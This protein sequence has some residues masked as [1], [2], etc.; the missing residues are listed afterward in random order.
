MKEVDRRLS[1]NTAN[2][3]S[4][5]LKP[6]RITTAGDSTNTVAILLTGVPEGGA[7]S[8]ALFNLY[9]DTLPVRIIEVGD[10]N[11]I[12]IYA[13]DI[14]LLA[15][16]LDE[17]Q[18]LLDVCSKWASEKKIVFGTDKCFAQFKGKTKRRLKL[19][20]AKLKRKKF[21]EYLGTQVTCFGIH[22]N[23]IWNRLKLMEIRSKE[24][25]SL[26]YHYDI[27]P[28]LARKIFKILLVPVMD[29]A[30]H[31]TPIEGDEAENAIKIAC[32]K[33][34]KALRTPLIVNSERSK[35]RAYN[36][37]NLWDISTRRYQAASKLY[38]RLRESR[39]LARE[40][41]KV[42]EEEM[43]DK[44]IVALRTIYSEY[45]LLQ[46]TGREVRKRK[47]YERTL[48]RKVAIGRDVDHPSMLLRPRALARFALRYHF[49]GEMDPSKRKKLIQLH[50]RKQVSIW[51]IKLRH[52]LSRKRALNEEERKDLVETIYC[53][54]DHLEGSL[55]S[56]NFKHTW[57]DSHRIEH[58][59]ELRR[60][61]AST[62]MAA[63][64]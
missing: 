11:C 40:D 52:Y 10:G 55:R 18:R 1:K 9:I 6:T 31:L 51:R 50:G 49:S 2:M 46:P 4:H 61:E 26:G 28:S 5:F 13:D 3:I 34:F 16:S 33:E 42:E 54:T 39:Q 36:I 22:A 27:H 14:I 24:L 38:T 7:I 47:I 21:A 59:R 57:K 12:I 8:P 58:Y 30:L 25:V 41:G 19:Q 23:T 44:E 45:E 20:G 43:I 53:C 56:R 29:Y 35:N 17:L 32:Y 60:L 63:E 37:Y 15:R 48:D 64:T 62:S